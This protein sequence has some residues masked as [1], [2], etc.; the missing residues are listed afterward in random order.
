MAVPVGFFAFQTAEIGDSKM[1]HVKQN[2][3]MDIAAV[4]LAEEQ[5]NSIAAYEFDGIGLTQ[6]E[7]VIMRNTLLLTIFRP[8]SFL[9]LRARKD[10]EVEYDEFQASC[11]MLFAK[12]I[13]HNNQ[14]YHQETTHKREIFTG[15]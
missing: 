9:I 1:S 8:C 5:E 11:E 12:G 13:K 4:V 14:T 10:R 15:C 2:P 7:P 3:A 6:A